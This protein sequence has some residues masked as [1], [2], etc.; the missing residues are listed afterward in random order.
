MIG[1]LQGIYYLVTGL[2]A[3]V[4]YPSFAR[5]TGP[6]SDV[7]LVK[8]IGLLLAVIGLVVLIFRDTPAA[9]LLGTLTALTLAGI[10]IFYSLRGT[11][12]KIYLGDALVELAFAAGWLLIIS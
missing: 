1:I 3:V 9:A 4:H 7:W 6:K 5:L 12:S 10:D 11:I 8:T 2:W